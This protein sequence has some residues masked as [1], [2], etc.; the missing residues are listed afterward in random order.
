[1]IGTAWREFHGR[2]DPLVGLSQRATVIVDRE[3]YRA[4]LAML[5][6]RDAA[7]AARIR[8]WGLDPARPHLERFADQAR[9]LAER[10]GK[11]EP[12]IEIHDADVHVDRERFAPLWSALIHA[13]RNAVDHGIEPGEARIA[14]G[15][16]WQGRLALRAASNGEH[17]I[18]EIEDDGAGIDWD[19]IA[20]RARALGSADQ[21]ADAVFAVGVSTAGELGEVSGCGVGMGSLRAACVALGGR[22]DL[23]SRRGGGT[24]VRCRV[25]LEHGYPRSIAAG[26]RA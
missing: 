25:P 12:E 4:V 26:Q 14:A 20:Q 5:G 6:D 21:G 15:K 10:L 2:I 8:R 13:V 24:I 18:V 3:D 1:V 9:Q 16:P 17:L 23:D 7:W 19:A 22:V 11:P